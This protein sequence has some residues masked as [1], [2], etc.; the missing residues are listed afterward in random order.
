MTH[1][2]CCDFESRIK[3]QNRTIIIYQGTICGKEM[4]SDADGRL[5]KTGMIVHLEGDREF[6]VMAAATGNDR[7][8]TTVDSRKDGRC[9]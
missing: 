8:P 9:R 6:S 2:S 1:N 5:V 4:S 7:R 3:V